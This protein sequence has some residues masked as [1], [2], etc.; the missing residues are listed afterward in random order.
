MRVSDWLLDRSVLFSFDRSGFERHRRRFDPSD[1]EVSLEG[2]I[3]AVTGANSGLGF[4]TASALAALDA[5]VW[6]LCRDEQRGET[7]RRAILRATGNE[8]LRLILLDLSRLGDIRRFVRDLGPRSPHVLIHNAGVLLDRR[9]ETD[10]GLES[11][12]ATH[13]V[14]PFLLTRLLLPRLRRTPDARVILVS[15]GG[16]YAQRLDLSDPQWAARPF[17]GVAAYAQAKRMQVVLGRLWA[18]RTAGSGIAFNSMHPGWADTRG[19]RHSLPRFHRWTKHRLRTPEQGADTIVWLAAARRAAYF[20]AG[21]WFDR[22]PAP[23]HLVPWT[24]ESPEDRERL[25][26]SCLEWAGATD[27]EGSPAP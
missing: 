11:T 21:F 2:R 23:L 7:A 15:S 24:R 12:L 4:A 1:L 25:W 9:V 22:R 5:E 18:E 8:R 19:V 6:L 27:P 13:V 17:D 14:G 10:D 3:C 20:N 16:M 26:R